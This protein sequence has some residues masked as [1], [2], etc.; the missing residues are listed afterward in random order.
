MEV[1]NNII[2]ID[3]FISFKKKSECLYLNDDTLKIINVLF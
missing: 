1:I 3:Y 2:D